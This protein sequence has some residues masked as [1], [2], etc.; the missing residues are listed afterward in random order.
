M[1]EPQQR[2]FLALPTHPAGLF[3]SGIFLNSLKLEFCLLRLQENKLSS[4][5][6]LTWNCD[7]RP[8]SIQSLV[9]C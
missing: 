7:L 5:D 2:W 3:N 1:Q 6:E 4:V 9:N 8:P